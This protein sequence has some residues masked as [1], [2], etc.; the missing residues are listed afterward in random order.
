MKK[1]IAVC[2]ISAMTAYPAMA[3]GL[4]QEVLQSAE[5]FDALFLN[6]AENS[7][8]LDGGV[9]IVIQTPTTA[10]V[11][12]IT[13][14]DAG[15]VTDGVNAS[16][17]PDVSITDVSTGV[18]GVIQTGSIDVAV[19]QSS[20]LVVPGMLASPRGTSTGWIST[21][22]DRSVIA[23]VP[24]AIGQ[25]AMSNTSATPLPMVMQPNGPLIVSNASQNTGNVYGGVSASGNMGSVE[26]NDISTNAMGVQSA[27]SISIMINNN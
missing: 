4:L 19:Q 1:S 24:L 23:S 13:D 20:L 12:A 10:G 14:L 7:A 11:P 9:T 8:L 26:I 5:S 6:S 3:E 25:A 17:S 18:T 22:P 21:T 16:Q 27:S 2:L 15:F